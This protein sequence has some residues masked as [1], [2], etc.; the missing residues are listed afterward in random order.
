MKKPRQTFSEA[1]LLSAGATVCYIY[2]LHASNDPECRPRYVGFTVNPK[3][4]Q[5]QHS[6][7]Q[8]SGSKKAWA[9]SVR[10]S[11]GRVILTIV[12]HFRSDDTSERGTVEATFIEK[13][14]SLYPDLLNDGGAGN[15]VARMTQRHRDAISRANKGKILSPTHAAK[16]RVARLGIPHSEEIRKKISESGRGKKRTPEQLDRYRQAAAKRWRDPKATKDF[17]DNL[18]KKRAEKLSDPEY[19]KRHSENLKRGHKKMHSD[20]AR[21]SIWL[22]KQRASQH[23]R[24]ADPTVR[25][26]L[27]EKIKATKLKRLLDEY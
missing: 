7:N 8:T 1:D 22:E 10:A 27:G 12:F 6:S 18:R 9:K 5:Y 24:F 11:G 13:Y 23:E 21:H 16:A 4:R 25:K 26:A 2:I 19:R 3:R 20:P 15:G 17:F 14:R